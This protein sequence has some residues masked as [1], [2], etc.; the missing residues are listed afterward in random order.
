VEVSG[1]SL[2]FSGGSIERQKGIIVTD[3][4]AGLAKLIIP[5]GVITYNVFVTCDVCLRAQE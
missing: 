5:E 4:F 1:C 2:K 3:N